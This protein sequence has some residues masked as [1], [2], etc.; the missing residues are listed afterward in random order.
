MQQF[1][2]HRQ[3]KFQ[4]ESLGLAAQVGSLLD[5]PEPLPPQRTDPHHAQIP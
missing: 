4:E 3:P 2:A 5:L 1:Y